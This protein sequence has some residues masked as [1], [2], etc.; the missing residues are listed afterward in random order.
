MK[1]LNSL[2]IIF[3]IICILVIAIIAVTILNF[4][5]TNIIDDT[6]EFASDYAAHVCITSYPFCLIQGGTTDLNL[7]PPL[8]AELITTFTLCNTT[9][10]NKEICEIF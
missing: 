8:C 2:N 3:L 4:N 6:K 1:I 10:N 5:Y 9:G 7:C